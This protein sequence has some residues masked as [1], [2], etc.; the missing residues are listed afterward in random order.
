MVAGGVVVLQVLVLK[1]IGVEIV[2]MFVV[3]VEIFVALH[4]KTNKESHSTVL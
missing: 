1:L 3:V 4:H 2:V